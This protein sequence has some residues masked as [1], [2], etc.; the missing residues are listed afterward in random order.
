MTSQ[1]ES[2]RPDDATIPFPCSTGTKA[3]VL[4]VHHRVP[5]GKA[6]FC[7]GNDPALG[8]WGAPVRLAWDEGDIW[9]ARVDLTMSKGAPIEY[10]FFV[11]PYNSQGTPDGESL[12]CRE[13]EGGGNHS[14]RVMDKVIGDVVVLHHWGKAGQARAWDEDGK[15][16]GGDESSKRTK[17][18]PIST[19]GPLDSGWLPDTPFHPLDLVPTAAE[20]DDLQCEYHRFLLNTVTGLH[21]RFITREGINRLRAKGTRVLMLDF[22]T[23]AEQCVSAIRGAVRIPSP[24][25]TPRD[26][27]DP[28]NS[29]LQKSIGLSVDAALDS[30]AVPVLEPGDAIVCYCCAGVRSAVAASALEGK[31]RR[32]VYAL[33][34]GIVQWFNEGGS[35]TNAMGTEVEA[36]H[37]VYKDLEK[38]VTRENKLIMESHAPCYGLY[39]DSEECKPMAECLR[40]RLNEEFEDSWLSYYDEPGLTWDENDPAAHRPPLSSP[41]VTGPWATPD[42]LPGDDPIL[43]TAEHTHTPQQDK[44]PSSSEDWE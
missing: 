7:V 29:A 6:V 40:E 32:P 41:D 36:I 34:G 30:G 20:K 2:G 33:F 38:Y 14:L 39:G 44:L 13:W 25:P 9:S 3:T 28:R 5:L 15:F 4:K 18:A 1:T 22:R 23:A 16:I 27:K 12:L 19:W 31:L 8:A 35:I 21:T 24:A 43:Q 26:L 37:P 10:K 42:A 17:R 11:A